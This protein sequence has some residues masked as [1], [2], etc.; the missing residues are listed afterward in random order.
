MANTP[1]TLH[2]DFPSTRA[3]RRVMKQ[4][5]NLMSQSPRKHVF[6]ETEL[7]SE[8]KGFF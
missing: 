1:N 3:L 2:F 4:T 6:L 5:E 8:A 7:T